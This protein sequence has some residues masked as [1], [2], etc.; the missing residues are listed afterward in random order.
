[1]NFVLKRISNIGKISSCLNSE[2]G[3]LIKKYL[4]TCKLINSIILSKQIDSFKPLTGFLY[5]LNT[6]LV[7]LFF[8]NKSFYA[9][10]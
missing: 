4:N 5:F 7:L 6:S 8:T 10:L 3:N 2:K 9:T 1:M